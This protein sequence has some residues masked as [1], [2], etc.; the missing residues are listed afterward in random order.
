MKA[1]R[2]RARP[3][4]CLIRT[5]VIRND[6]HI[7]L[8]GGVPTTIYIHAAGVVAI[9]FGVAAVDASLGAVFL[10]RRQSGRA[11][12]DAVGASV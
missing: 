2:P 6:D 8:E 12:A 11:F 4:L 1:A 7:L 10:G 3:L 9:R 5:Y